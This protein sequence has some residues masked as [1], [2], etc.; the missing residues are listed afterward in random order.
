M[1]FGDGGSIQKISIIMESTEAIIEGN[2]HCGML[3]KRYKMKFKK[4]NA[5]L[6]EF[7]GGKIGEAELER[8]LRLFD[9]KV[10]IEVMSDLCFS[11]LEEEHRD[12][13]VA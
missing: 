3:R 12:R 11:L 9:R 1:E 10:T 13:E 4:I 2:Y 5:L 8:R 6:D 7:E